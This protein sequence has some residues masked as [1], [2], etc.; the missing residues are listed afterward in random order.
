M[1]RKL[2]MVV[3]IVAVMIVGVVPAA[4][5]AYAANKAALRGFHASCGHFSVDVTVTGLTDDQAGWDRFRY[6]V[7]DGAGKLLYR[8]DSA[9]LVGRSDR[10][11]VVHMPYA[12]NAEPTANPI[13]F[14][15]VDLDILAR[16]IG[17]VIEQQVE[18]AC[19][20]GARPTSRLEALLPDGVKGLMRLESP[21]YTDPNGAALSL[22]VERG[23]EFTALYVSPDRL[24][25]AIYVGGENLVWV[26]SA[27]IDLG[28]GASRLMSPPYTLDP[29]QQVTGVVIP[30]VAVST[31]R[32]NYTL[33]LRQ[34]PST[35]FATITKIPS[36][37]VI[38]VYGRT[39]NSGWILVSF[40]GLGG[41]VASRFVTMIDVPLR[42]LPVVG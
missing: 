13:R 7:V 14:Q 40:N 19:F 30:G 36:R 8:E 35:R 20:V 27:D 21:L 26:R 32:V 25:T 10:A 17:T 28:A 2:M 39:A 4:T 41:W 18:S 5:P 29:S 34:G 31:A 38:A 6:Q 9:R 15:V 3:G 12:K 37:S 22:R 1:F 23:R 24:W 16:P 11:W 42:S 33:R